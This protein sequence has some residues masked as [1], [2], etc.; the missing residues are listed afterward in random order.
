[1]KRTV[2]VTGGAR[3]IGA[4]IAKEFR[5]HGHD[6]LTPTRAELDLASAASVE[7]FIRRTVDGPIDVLINNAGI[8]VLN[9]I[10]TLDSSAWQEMLQVNLTSPV[11]LTQALLPGMQARGWGRIVCVSSI[12]SLITKPKRVA[13][14]MTKAALNAFVRSL[15]VEG[16]AGGVLANSLCPGYVDTAL[17]R[18]NNSPEEIAALVKA[19]PAQRLAQP[20]E[21]ARVAYFL[22]SDENT[23]IS[24]QAIVADGGF[25]CQ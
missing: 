21:L 25:L 10:D 3:G 7:D 22:G 20:E 16:G 15:A 6:V 9:S 11:R 24:G 1:M 4:A 13:Y 17:T 2:L 8:N 5:D 23:Y 12:F 14:S 18:Q 19:I